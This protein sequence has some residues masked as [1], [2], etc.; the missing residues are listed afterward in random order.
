MVP[1]VSFLGTR[2]TLAHSRR[3]PHTCLIT[4]WRIGSKRASRIGPSHNNVHC[5]GMRP[6]LEASNRPSYDIPSGVSFR[7]SMRWLPGKRAFQTHL[8]LQLL[9]AVLSG[10][11][12]VSYPIYWLADF[13]DQSATDNEIGYSC[14][15]HP[16]TFTFPEEIHAETLVTTSGI[17]FLVLRNG[18]P[19][20]TLLSG[21]QYELQ[22]GTYDHLRSIRKCRRCP[23]STLVWGS[24]KPFMIT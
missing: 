13:L 6:S 5:L 16:T 20:T 1:T 14:I 3:A 21:Q 12:V 8:L 22:V 7:D 10:C 17:S 24:C 11:S 9:I 2:G 23:P 4:H 18:S 15:S 19:A